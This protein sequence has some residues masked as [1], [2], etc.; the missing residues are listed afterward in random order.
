MSNG[1]WDFSITFS[2]QEV[3]FSLK[4]NPIFD[5]PLGKRGKLPMKILLHS[6]CAP[7]LLAP[8]DSLL[9]EGHEITALF[10]NPNIM[11]YREFRNRLT[12]FRDYAQEHSI[13]VMIDESYDLESLLRKYLERGA[14]PRCL[15]CYEMRLDHTARM[16]S[17]K[18]FDAFSTTLSVSP[19][20]NHEFIQKAGE[21]ATSQYRKPF[22]YRDWR[23]HFIEAHEKAK[24]LHLYLQ[25][26]CGCIFSEEER[27]RK[28]K[29]YE[30]G[31]R[32]AE[33]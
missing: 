3:S 19:Y 14:T 9:E 29:K 7:C 23:P 13:P 21:S 15:V 4:P 10:H 18:G 24:N 25:A 28:R 1:F 16:A 30:C 31:T 27:Y 11:P 6:C 20:Q 12:A 8:Y 26:Y 5:N 33:S 17:E 22:L 2:L 32:N